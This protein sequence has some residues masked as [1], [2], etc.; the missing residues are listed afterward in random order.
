M[1]IYIY[2]YIYVRNSDKIKGKILVID[3]NLF[4]GFLHVSFL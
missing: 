3:Q 1:Y 4:S 2:I